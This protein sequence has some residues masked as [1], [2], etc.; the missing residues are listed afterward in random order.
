MH[1]VLMGL[2]ENH[3]LKWFSVSEAGKEYFVGKQLKQVSLKLLNI[4]PSYHIER[5]PRDLEKHYANF[6]AT[7]HLALLSEAAYFLLGDKIS[8]TNLQRAEKLLDE[9]YCQ[10][11][12]LYGLGS[13][14]LNVHN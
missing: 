1:A 9:F 3:L 12:E 6:K 7:E 2:T 13:C 5:L 4:K 8:L 11:P 14:G 10:F